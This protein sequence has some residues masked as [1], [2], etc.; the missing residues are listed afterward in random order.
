MIE[1]LIKYYTDNLT[2][3]A[4]V[5]K[6]NGCLNTLFVVLLLVV[7]G[8]PSFSIIFYIT[9]KTKI[10]CIANKADQ[11]AP[12]IYMLFII[13][14]FLLLL[15][16][17]SRLS[18]CLNA[19]TIKQHYPNVYISK[20]SYSRD[21]F[22]EMV[23]LQLD[24]YIRK[25]KLTDKIDDIQKIINEKAKNERLP[26][27]LYLGALIALCLPLWSSY[28]DKVFTFFSD[29]QSISI[30]A[31]VLLL[32]ITS[33]TIIVPSIYVFIDSFFSRYAKLT[34]L[35]ELLDEYKLSDKYKTLKK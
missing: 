13:L 16:C 5:I 18:R 8:L 21:K 29:I 7:F 31:L 4:L 35:S 10:L 20:H 30:I 14:I 2:F 33:L 9:N 25:E 32:P 19:K 22:N 1:K 3:K 34:K 6:K 28:V 24:E 27:T 11:W 26:F 17:V 15:F 12:V 23:L